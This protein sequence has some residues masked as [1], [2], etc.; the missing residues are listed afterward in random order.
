VR[1]PYLNDAGFFQPL[2]HP[3]EGRLT[4]MPF[5]VAFSE[6]R[7]EQN[8]PPPRLGEHTKEVLGELGFSAEEMGKI[9]GK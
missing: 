2:D 3:T 6:T 7:L 1:D 9:I 8:L 5:P 4:T